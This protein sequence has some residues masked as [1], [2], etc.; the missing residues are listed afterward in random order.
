MGDIPRNAPLIGRQSL[1]LRALFMSVGIVILL[2]W[3]AMPVL[4]RIP[5]AWLEKNS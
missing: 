2:T 4:V 1:A 3:V 5:R